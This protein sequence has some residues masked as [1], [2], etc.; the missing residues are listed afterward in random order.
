MRKAV[1]LLYIFVS[2][3]CG[4]RVEMT[5]IAKLNGYWEIEKVI[6]S[7]GNEKE[8]KVNETIDYFKVNGTTGFRKKVMPQFDGTYLENGDA[9][10]IDVAFKE[11]K[12]FLNYT[13]NYAK[14]KEEIISISD[15]KLVLRNGEV[16]YYYK[17]PI[18][19]SLK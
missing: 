9:E 15:D 6:L 13:T 11:K 5:D 18:P 1:I 10:K 14:W 3:S 7:D 4:Q 19:F 16:E 8:Y 2:I 17:K 12:A